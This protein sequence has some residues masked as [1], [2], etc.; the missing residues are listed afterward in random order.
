MGVILINLQRGLD[1]G[2]NPAAARSLTL[3]ARFPARR[4]TNAARLEASVTALFAGDALTRQVTIMLE[5]RLT[6]LG[7]TGAEYDTGDSHRRNGDQFSSGFVDIN[8]TQNPG[9]AR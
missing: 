6:A 9:A 3:I 8:R 5:R 7:V 2:I 1:V 4:T